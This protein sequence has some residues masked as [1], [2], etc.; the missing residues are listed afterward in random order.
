MPAYF[1]AARRSARSVAWKPDLIG[2]TDR[3]DPHIS[4]LIKYRRVR[5]SLV[6][7]VSGFLHMLHVT[8]S[9]MYFFIRLSICFGLYLP[10]ICRCR[11]K[12]A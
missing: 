2:A 10:L 12:R 5:L 4:H 8:Y 6:R 7:V 9:M 11:V 3:D 1:L